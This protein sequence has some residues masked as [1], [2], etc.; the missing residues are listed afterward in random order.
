MKN[1]KRCLEIQK[2]LSWNVRCNRMSEQL[3][4][5][6]RNNDTAGREP[7]KIPWAL[8]EFHPLGKQTEAVNLYIPYSNSPNLNVICTTQQIICLNKMTFPSSE[9]LKHNYQI[10]GY[11]PTHYMTLSLM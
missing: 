10:S 5:A 2:Q 9:L 6:F 11:F 1:I 3:L 8:L 7:L 4:F